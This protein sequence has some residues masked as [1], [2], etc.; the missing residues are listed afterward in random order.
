VAHDFNNLLAAIIGSAAILEKKLQ[1]HSQ[2]LKQVKRIQKSANRRAELTRKLLGFSRYE[3]KE[4]C[5]IDVKQCV[6]NVIDIMQ[7]TIDKRITI[8]KQCSL[9]FRCSIT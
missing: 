2:A 4:P 6:E 9:Y 3:N 8:K 5:L 7:H 1:E